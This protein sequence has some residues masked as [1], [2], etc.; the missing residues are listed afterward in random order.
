MTEVLRFFEELTE[1][2]VEPSAVL[3]NRALPVDVGRRRT[4]PI[5]DIP[6]AEIRAAL[7][8]NLVRWGGESRRQTCSMEG[9][10]G[11]YGLPLLTVPWMPEPPMAVE[12]LTW[13]LNEVAG[14]DD[15]L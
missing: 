14:L 6:D 7:K 11:R 12:N 5:R 1:V 13:L 2:E 3:L 4:R 8:A 15:L 10:A 9:I